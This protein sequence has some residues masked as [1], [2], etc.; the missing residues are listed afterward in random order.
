MSWHY[1]QVYSL[2]PQFPLIFE[3]LISQELLFPIWFQS[4]FLWT[5][6]SMEE[7]MLVLQLN[8][9]VLVG[10]GDDDSWHFGLSCLRIVLIVFEVSPI[11]RGFV[12]HRFTFDLILT[13]KC[14]RIPIKEVFQV[15]DND[16]LWHFGLSYSFFLNFETLFQLVWWGSPKCCGLS[17]FS[18]LKV[19]AD[20]WWSCRRPFFSLGS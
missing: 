13:S 20:S 8:F 17:C 10:V 15:V 7:T 5:T 12:S 16:S 1:C 6:R 9:A 3:K 19:G 2:V 18:S 11:F 14:L 4:Y